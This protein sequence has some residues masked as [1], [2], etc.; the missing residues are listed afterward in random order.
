[1]HTQ[2]IMLM[3]LTTVHCAVSV[4]EWIYWAGLRRLLKHMNV[5]ITVIIILVLVIN[6]PSLLC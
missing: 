4:C 2:I 5:F 1:M 6:F 3:Y